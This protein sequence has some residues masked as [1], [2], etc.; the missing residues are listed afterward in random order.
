M[1]NE[2]NLLVEIDMLVARLEE[3]YT[4]EEILNGLDEYLAL[5][6]EFTPIR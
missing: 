1:N 4:S 5:A 2:S 6:D 3:H